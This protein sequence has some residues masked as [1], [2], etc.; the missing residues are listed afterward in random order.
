[1]MSVS[2][3]SAYFHVCQIELDENN[4]ATGVVYKRNGELITVKANKEIVVSAGAINSPQLLMLSGIG[5]SAHLRSV[6]VSLRRG[7]NLMQKFFELFL[8]STLLTRLSPKLS[9][10]VLE[11]TWRTMSLPSWVPSFSTH[12]FPLLPS[13]IWIRRMQ[14][15]T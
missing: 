13:G 10:P 4:R 9:S 3:V 7:V 11:S 8:R 1:M 6:G 14:M 12:Q 2:E 5:Q 15:S